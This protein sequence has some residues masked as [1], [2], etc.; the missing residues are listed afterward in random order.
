MAI[1]DQYFFPAPAKLNLFLHVL[2]QLEN[3]YHAL[4]S[5]FQL[6]ALQD[7][8]GLEV[9]LRSSEIHLEEPQGLTCGT[10]NLAYRAARMLQE[11]TGCTK[12][13][14]IQLHK[15]I[16]VGAGLGGGSSDAATVLVGLNELWQLKCSEQELLRL[17][18]RLGS[19]VPFFIHGKNAWVTGTG[20]GLTDMEMPETWFLVVY[21]GVQVSTGQIFQHSDLTRGTP[22]RTIAR[23]S[24]D[25][26]NTD[27]WSNDL[28]SVV[29]RLFPEVQSAKNW[30]SQWGTVKMTG[31]GSS[32][33]LDVGS[34]E[35]GQ[36]VLLQIPK[37]W[38]GYLIPSLNSSSLH[39][40]LQ[41]YQ[42]ET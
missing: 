26:G 19:D 40:R 10:D 42:S 16:P 35:N 8:I 31:S 3:G 13:V 39:T 32:V 7:L 27:S 25:G 1:E 5:V 15:N 17:G 38:T 22:A 33:F 34:E 29:F 36:A 30:L 6:I 23:F 2:G 11:A 4:Q 24:E 12:G 41:R 28:E 21:P 18:G 37:K 9:D 14:R 20:D